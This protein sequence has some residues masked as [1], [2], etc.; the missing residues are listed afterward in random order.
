MKAVTGWLRRLE[1]PKGSLSDANQ[2]FLEAHKRSMIAKEG[3]RSAE[4][5]VKL[6]WKLRV[7]KNSPVG[8]FGIWDDEQN[9]VYWCLRKRIDERSKILS[10]ES[11]STISEVK[12]NQV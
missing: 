12:N 5:L 9:Y 7:H 3:I 8:M 4:S 10:E 2:R 6:L 11:R 1:S